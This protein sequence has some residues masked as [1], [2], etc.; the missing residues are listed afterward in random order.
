MRKSLITTD[1]IQ[2]Y[3]LVIGGHQGLKLYGF[4]FCVAAMNGI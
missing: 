1:E 4:Q 2:K 3:E